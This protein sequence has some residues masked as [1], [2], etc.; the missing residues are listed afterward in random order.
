[1]SYEDFFLCYDQKKR[2]K[3]WFSSENL[4]AIPNEVKYTSPKAFCKI[5]IKIYI[6]SPRFGAFYVELEMLRLIRQERERK[7]FYPVLRLNAE[8]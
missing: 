4:T 2:A 7:K 5:K 3:N 8:K 1:M 6:V